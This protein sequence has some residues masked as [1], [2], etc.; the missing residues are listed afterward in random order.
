MIEGIWCPNVP[1]AWGCESAQAGVR[2]CA[3]LFLRAYLALH[4][5]AR[6]CFFGGFVVLVVFSVL[7]GRF[8]CLALD[9]VQFVDTAM[10]CIVANS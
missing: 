6:L 5:H 10:I 4:P 9:S 1:R 8:L 7:F 3:R 2:L